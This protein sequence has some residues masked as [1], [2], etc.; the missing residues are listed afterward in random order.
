MII[1]DGC[2]TCI[3]IHAPRTGSDPT[4][5]FRPRHGGYFNPRSP[6]GE[7]QLKPCQRVILR[8]FQSTLPARGA[9]ADRILSNMRQIISIHAPR[10]GSD[11]VVGSRKIPSPIFQSTLP[12][13]GATLMSSNFSQGF[14]FQS[15]LPARGATHLAVRTLCLRN[16]NPRSPH[17]ERH[18]L[19]DIVDVSQISIHAPRTGSDANLILQIYTRQNFNPRSPHGERRRSFIKLS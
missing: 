4:L 17:G 2:C 9:T 14:I 19:Q 15:T 16:F 12:A 3:S 10:T 7:R 8:K 6:H 13:R 5:S 18:I 11:N 1:M